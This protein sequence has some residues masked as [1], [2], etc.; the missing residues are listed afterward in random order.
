MV[1]YMKLKPTQTCMRLTATARGSYY[2]QTTDPQRE[3]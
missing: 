2:L 1:K 3:N